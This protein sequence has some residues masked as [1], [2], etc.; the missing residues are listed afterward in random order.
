[1]RQG[2][3]VLGGTAQRRGRF[4]VRVTLLRS[5]VSVRRT[6]RLTVR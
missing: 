5:D 3:V 6:F 4:D 2:K 1:V